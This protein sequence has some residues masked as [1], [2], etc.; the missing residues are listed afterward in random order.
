VI[1]EAFRIF[2]FILTYLQLGLEG[3]GGRDRRAVAAARALLH[4]TNREEVIVSIG[5]KWS[6]GF[7]SAAVFAG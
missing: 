6:Q 2:Y 5:S 3:L 4:K 1:E 7:I